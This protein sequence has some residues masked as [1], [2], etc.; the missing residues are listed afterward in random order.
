MDPSTSM[1]VTDKDSTHRPHDSPS[2]HSPAPPLAPLEYLQNQR[3]GSITDPSL[4]AASPNHQNP[5]LASS[6]NSSGSTLFRHQEFP[7][8]VQSHPSSNSL[9]PQSKN[10][11][12]T[13]RPVS[14]YIFGDASVQPTDPSNPQAR[15]LLHNASAERGNGGAFTADSEEDWLN[16]YDGTGEMPQSQNGQ[17][18]AI[19]FLQILTRIDS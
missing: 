1:D 13:T 9:D 8:P 6:S 18:G 4:H 12:L 3:R 7:H 11:Q 10:P 15:R 5:A 2:R 14:P 19:G 16:A 17:H